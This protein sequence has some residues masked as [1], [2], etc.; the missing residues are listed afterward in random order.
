MKEVRE[1]ERKEEKEERKMDGTRTFLILKPV[2]PI[3]V[4]RT[5]FLMC[6]SALCHVPFDHAKWLLFRHLCH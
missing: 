6:V 2:E 5:Y 1:R 4:I 3:C